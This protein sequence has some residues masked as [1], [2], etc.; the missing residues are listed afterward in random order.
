MYHP[1][2]RSGAQSQLKKIG[3]A[4]LVVGLPTYK[5]AEAAA[6]V[7][8]AALEGLQHYYPQLRTVLINAD[9]GF[10]ATVRRTV[11]AQASSNGHHTRLVTG[12]YEGVLGQGSATAALLDAALALDARAIVILD[13]Q[14]TVTPNWIAGLAHLILEE[15]ADLVMPR[16]RQ[17]PLAEGMLNDLILYPL[18]RALW[19]Q[20]I[21]YPAA[22][23]FA[24]CPQ[25]ATAL[26]D[27]DIW[28][29]AAAMFGLPTWLASYSAVNDWRVAQ[30][31]LGKKTD[32]LPQTSALSQRQQ[33]R[34]ANRVETQFKARF[35]D[36]LTVMFSLAH[37]Y[38][39]CWKTVG[40]IR[41]LP[42]LTQFASEVKMEPT[43]EQDT[44]WLLDKLALGW[45]D[46][47]SIW[48]YVLTPD[49]LSYL[50]AV[51]A[52]PPEQFYFP[53]DLWSRI[54]YDFVIVFN[55]GETDPVQIIEALFPLYQGRLAAFRQ[56]VAGLALVGREGTVA[57]QAVDFEETR[58]YFEERWQVYQPWRRNS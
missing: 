14:S 40:D 33:Q 51:A 10:E 42:T 55:K 23:D 21:R 52:L 2:L 34:W 45:I 43:S 56:E 7:A 27:E 58:S 50:E 53:S 13:S 47:R 5:N 9:A 48:Q 57:A 6:Q 29:T 18:F 19:G 24:L 30:S 46:F 17:W 22:S 44:V 15:K 20:S 25:L 41:S 8:Q 39:T 49:N 36:T 38:Q 4:D 32:Y 26:L 16:Y 11:A 31:A 3:S 28:E 12:R 54:I 1:I 37:K 35:H